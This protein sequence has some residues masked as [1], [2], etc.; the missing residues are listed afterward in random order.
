MKSWM[1]RLTVLMFCVFAA[2]ACREEPQL[3]EPPAV[4]LAL[5]RRDTLEFAAALRAV[6]MVSDATEQLAYLRG[7]GIVNAAADLA[8]IAQMRSSCLKLSTHLNRVLFDYG[9]PLYRPNCLDAGVAR[10]GRYHVIFMRNEPA[11]R[12]LDFEFEQLFETRGEISGKGRLAED[13]TTQT[14]TYEIAVGKKDPLPLKGEHR[15]AYTSDDYE[16]SGHFAWGDGQKQARFDNLALH[17]GVSLPSDGTARFTVGDRAIDVIFSS[18][19][20]KTLLQAFCEGEML[21]FELDASG[22]LIEKTQEPREKSDA[23]I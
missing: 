14:V 8:R 1:N 5:M 17:R 15:L 12:L 21:L 18:D 10:S 11:G 9:T 6:L 7:N 3:P 19:D 20:A 23:E 2:M 16:I 22:Q 4:D 13:A